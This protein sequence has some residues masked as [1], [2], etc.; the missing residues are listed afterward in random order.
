MSKNLVGK[1]SV[2]LSTK[3]NILNATIILEGLRIVTQK[4]DLDD[5]ALVHWSASGAMGVCPTHQPMNICHI[6]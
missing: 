3:N 4:D 1:A 2:C 6:I 5:V